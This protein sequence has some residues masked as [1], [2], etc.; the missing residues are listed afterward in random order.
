MV[1]RHAQVGDK[2]V[3]AADANGQRN[4]E[5]HGQDDQQRIDRSCYAY[6]HVA[7]KHVA[8]KVDQW[9]AWDDKEGTG[10]QR[11]PRGVGVKYRV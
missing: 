4:A 7:V 1:G 10:H 2:V 11:V 9:D 8:D 3:D 5:C 6:F